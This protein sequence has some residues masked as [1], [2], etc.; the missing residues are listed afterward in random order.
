MLRFGIVAFV[1]VGSCAAL[2]A[3]EVCVACQEPAKT[4]RCS[5]SGEPKSLGLEGDDRLENHVCEYVLAKTNSHTK[6]KAIKV[7]DAPC[8]GV[9]RT[10]T[11]RDYVRLRTAEGPSTH[12]PGAHEVVRKSVNS[13]WVCMTSL[14]QDC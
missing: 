11:L 10:V 5:V 12:D 13:A 1:I 7:G 2:H 6:C 9:P 3:A 4:Y 8:D 14:F